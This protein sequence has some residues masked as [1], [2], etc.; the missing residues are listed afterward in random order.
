MDFVQVD[1]Y[2]A[3]LK[4]KDDLVGIYDSVN[5]KDFKH[6]KTELAKR[7]EFTLVCLIRTGLILLMI[8]WPILW[9]PA[10]FLW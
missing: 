5:G 7:Y 6:L 2:G 10:R 4:N 1:S 8:S 3:W 9:I